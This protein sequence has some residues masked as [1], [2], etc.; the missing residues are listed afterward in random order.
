A[1]DA[2]DVLAAPAGEHR[3]RG[4]APCESLTIVGE[5]PERLLQPLATH[6][7]CKPPRTGRPVLWHQDGAFWPLEPMEVTTLWLAITDSDP[8]NGCLRVIPGTHTEELAGMQERDDVDS[9]LRRET[10][11]QVDESQAVDLELRAGDVSV[12][13]PNILHSSEANTSDRWRRALTIRYIPTSTRI[14]DP[15]AASPFL[16]RGDAVD[17]VN[18]YRELPRFREDE[19]MAFA[20]AESWRH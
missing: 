10:D 13:H 15:D 18:Q 6:Y 12:H 20:G 9:V 4:H 19:H 3:E 5:T 8:E 16:L 17:G 1:C 2:I 7:L 14:T 11:Y